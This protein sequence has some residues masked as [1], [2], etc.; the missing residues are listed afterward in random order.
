MEDSGPVRY[1]F[2]T[3][4]RVLWGLW[5]AFAA[6]YIV[7]GYLPG[8]GPMDGVWVSLS[9][10][11]G[12]LTSGFTYFAGHLVRFVLKRRPKEKGRD[13]VIYIFISGLVGLFM[14]S[15][16]WTWF[17][18]DTPCDHPGCDDIIATVVVEEVVTVVVTQGSGSS[19]VSPEEQATATARME[20]LNTAIVEH[21]TATAT[22]REALTPTPEP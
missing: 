5:A 21:A 19:T 15:L 1:E 22:A 11:G 2:K 8:Q 17:G 20:A 4:W 18:P 6:L 7:I 3:N 13:A 10:L 9:L 14:L 16:L 12:G